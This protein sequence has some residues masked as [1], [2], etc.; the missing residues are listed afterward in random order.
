MK[1]AIRLGALSQLKAV[2]VFTHDSIGLEEDGPTHQPIEH[3]AGLRG[4]PGLTVIRPADPN[5]TVEAWAFAVQHDGP[6]LLVLTRQTVAHLDR[7]EA[8]DPAVAHGAYVLADVE[9]G[10]PD[11][12]LIGTGSEVSL[13]V[14]ARE[15]LKNI[16]V[17]AR[18]VSMPSWSLF[19]AQ[20]DSYRERVLPRGIKKRVTVEA[21]SPIGWHRWATDEGS[22][23]GVERFGASAPGQEVLAHLG[24]TADHIAAAALRLLGK[25]NKADQE[26]TR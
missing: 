15:K 16:G 21:G 22:V 19:E 2:Y 6:T 8:I 20:E 11:V 23:I 14:Q 12:I 1:P 18:V 4:V 5:E 9:G 10:S 3:L 7:S 13:C 25:N 17:K 26:G 24:L